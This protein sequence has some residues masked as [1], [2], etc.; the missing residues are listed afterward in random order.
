MD[1]VYDNVLFVMVWYNAKMAAMSNPHGVPLLRV[2]P[3]N[4]NA[5]TRNNAFRKAFYVM[6]M[7]IV[8][9]NYVQTF[10]RLTKSID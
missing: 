8:S 7:P 9:T 4:S 10:M 6:E 5:N 3:T 1:G 2:H